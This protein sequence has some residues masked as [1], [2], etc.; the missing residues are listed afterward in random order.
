M[1]FHSSKAGPDR[2][3]EQLP[4][5][6]PAGYAAPTGPTF[7]NTPTAQIQPA[8][9]AGAAQNAYQGQLSNYENTWNNIGKL[10]VAAAG[11]AGAPFTGGLSLGAA[12][13]LGGMFGGSP[14]PMTYGGPSGPTAFYGNNTAGGW[15]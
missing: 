1:C 15:G 14:G 2:H 12:G 8:N 6:S 11:L 9:Y 3:S 10:G 7:L 5:S 13:A 4:D